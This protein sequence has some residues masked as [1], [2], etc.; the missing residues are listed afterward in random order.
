MINPNSDSGCCIS[1]IVCAYNGDT[2]LQN[3]LNSLENQDLNNGD[4]EIIVIDDE[5]LDST[6]V[7]CENWIESMKDKAPDSRYIRIKHGGLSFARNEGIRQAKGE[8]VSFIDDDAVAS[9]TWLSSIVRAFQENDN[10][11]IIGGDVRLLNDHVPFARLVYNSVFYYA[12]RNVNMAIG[13]NMS[14]RK[15]LFTHENLFHPI[16]MRRGDETYVFGK[17]KSHTT[18]IN[19]KNAEVYH[20]SPESMRRWLI[21]R[22]DNGYF[23]AQIGALNGKYINDIFML[24][25]RLQYLALPLIVILLFSLSKFLFASAV[26][27]YFLCLIARRYFKGSY[28]IK[29]V[30]VYTENRNN[31][32]HSAR[33][34][35]PSVLAIVL[36]GD[37]SNDIG[38]IYGM[39]HYRRTVKMKDQNLNESAVIERAISN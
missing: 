34:G 30:K 31:S 19:I 25:Y 10:Y 29:L 23:T 16:L 2:T 17:L 6:Q 4:Y 27:L 20:E 33:W 32:K 21:T 18:P 8:I 12:M 24:F 37:I 5:S 28:L 9:K 36:F 11:Q 39:L 15:S 1:V 35:V 26:A 7:I 22:Y 13:T 38:Y 3:C 14:F